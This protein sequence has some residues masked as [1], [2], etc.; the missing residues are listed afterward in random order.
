MLT[1]STLT[2]TII[3]EALYQ[4]LTDGDLDACLKTIQTNAETMLKEN[5]SR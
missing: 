5:A 3:R 1:P 4:V 2:Y